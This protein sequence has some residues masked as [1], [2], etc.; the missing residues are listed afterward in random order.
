MSAPGHALVAGLAG[1]IVDEYDDL[2][3]QYD[4]VAGMNARLERQKVRLEEENADLQSAN[5]QFVQRVRELEERLAV[6][7][8]ARAKT[9]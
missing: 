3:E 8:G 4:A 5:D 6:L 1:R 2:A 9:G 7:S